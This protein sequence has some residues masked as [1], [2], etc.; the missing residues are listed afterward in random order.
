MA[1]AFSFLSFFL[2]FLLGL[3]IYRL[4]DT[5]LRELRGALEAISK[6]VRRL[7]LFYIPMLS[8]LLMIILVSWLKESAS[9]TIL[10][11]SLDSGI[12]DLLFLCFLI[13]LHSLTRIFKTDLPDLFCEYKSR[14]NCSKVVLFNHSIACLTY[15]ILSLWFLNGMGTITWLTF[16]IGRFA[17]LDQVDFSAIKDGFD[18]QGHRRTPIYVCSFII[19]CLIAHYLSEYIPSAFAYV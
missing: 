19:S 12:I 18:L 14:E 8:T 11:F 2:T 7:A 4:S 5:H 9:K 16:L 1:L 15:V 6:P 3:M 13:A 10:G 17:W